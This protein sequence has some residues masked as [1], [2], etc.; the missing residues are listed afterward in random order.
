MKFKEYLKELQRRHVVK[1]GI[2]YLVAAWLLIQVLDI[3]V[4]AFEMGTGWLQTFIIVLSVGFPV[5]LIIAWVYDFT[6]DGIKKTEEI[7]DDKLSY[8][9]QDNGLNRFIIGG[10]SVAVVLLLA[11]T[12]RLGNKVS[13]GEGKTLTTENNSSMAILPFKDL[14]PDQDQGY[15]SDGLSRSIYDRL[16]G[17]KNLKLISPTSSFKFRD[18][19]V[20]IGSIA[21]ELD[22]RYIMEG[23][24]QLIGDQYRASINL[25]D[26]WNG[27]TIWSK[28]FDDHLENVLAVYD[29][30]AEGVSDYLNVTLSIQ[31]VQDRKVDP[32]AYLLFLKA[33]DTTNKTAHSRAAVIFADSLIRMSLKID[34]TYA[35]S[36]ILRTRTIFHLTVYWGLIDKQIGLAL[37]KKSALKAIELDPE[38]PWGYLWV[39]NLSWH[40]RDITTYEKYYDLMVEKVDNHA[41]VA[42]YQGWCK[43]R[44][45]RVMEA[46]PY[47]EQAS[48]LDPKNN[49]YNLAMTF[50]ELNRSELAKA[51]ERILTIDNDWI[52]IR[53][54]F[55]TQVKVDSGDYAK[56]EELM[57]SL[58]AYFQTFLRIKKLAHEGKSKEALSELSQFVEYQNDGVSFFYFGTEHAHPWILAQLYSIVGDRDRAFEYL[59]IAY[60]VIVN[61]VEWFFSDYNLLSLHDDV[62]WAAYLERL[63]NEFGYDFM[64]KSSKKQ[65][66]KE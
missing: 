13:E 29:E 18:Q 20:S 24:V 39:S 49:E 55:L 61:Y 45:N 10:L 34:P 40:D 53:I 42:M 64:H 38:D 8:S 7:A 51:T 12:I 35:P 44:T 1:A 22:V 14:S 65:K 52:L 19:D 54:F 25:V 46:Y 21:E 56:A 33:N 66:D 30:V 57:E 9:S 26:S 36:Q 43:R 60:P 28:S 11:N 63:G 62:R 41:D 23:G 48:F 4:D 16:A 50:H 3:L 58:P 2:A 31:D 32:E 15:F 59:D 5:W 27:T 47:D 37:A 6:P 17:N